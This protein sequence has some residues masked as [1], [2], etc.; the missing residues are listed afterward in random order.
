MCP[1]PLTALWRRKLEQQH[2]RAKWP[3]TRGR[4]GLDKAD[5]AIR[6]LQRDA[7][8]TQLVLVK[9][10]RRKLQSEEGTA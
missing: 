8:E 6:W 2:G 4:Q 1:R 7:E 3:Q 5:G 9:R 10:A